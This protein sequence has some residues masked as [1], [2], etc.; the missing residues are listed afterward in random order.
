MRVDNAIIMAAGASSRFAPLS[1]ERHKALTI[2]KQEILIER[3]I[4]QLIEAGISEIYIVTGYK[5]EQFEYLQEKYNVKLIHNNEYLSRNNNG[6]IWTARNV[7]NNSYICSA[8]NYFDI[9]PF[10]Y[11]EKGA[12]YA[13]EYSDTYTQ[14]WCMKEDA[15][16]FISSVEIGGKK[17]WFMIGHAFWDETYSSRFL[18]ILGEEYNLDHTKKKLWEAIYL[19][20]LD[21][22]RMK[23]K[24][25]NAGTIHEF[26]TIDDLRRFDHSYIIDSR[27][28]ILKTIASKMGVKEEHL[29]NFRAVKGTTAEAVGFEFDCENKTYKYLYKTGE[30]V[31]Q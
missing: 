5:A 31:R 25:Y 9:N 26:D 17:A 15:N 27:S 3:Q 21:E 29:H 1:Y 20:H 30:M 6:S 18:R 10:Q 23:I 19:E 8:D 13:A 16:G 12:F 2:V 4:K 22:L 14:E 7:I 28:K 11:D 24:K